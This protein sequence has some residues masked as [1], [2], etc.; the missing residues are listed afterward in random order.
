MTLLPVGS[1]V[2]LAEGYQKMVDDNKGNLPR[3]RAQ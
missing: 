1:V 3:G 2:Y